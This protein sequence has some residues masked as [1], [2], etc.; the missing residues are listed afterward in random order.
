MQQR[1]EALVQQ[2][3]R[4]QQERVGLARPAGTIQQR[5]DLDG[6][7]EPHFIRQDTCRS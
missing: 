1:A 3:D 7:S 6:L 5:A 4:H 2:G